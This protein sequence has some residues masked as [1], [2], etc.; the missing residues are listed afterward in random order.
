MSHYSD[1]RNI[2]SII[3][4]T[5]QGATDEALVRQCLLDNMS[6]RLPKQAAT[7][8]MIGLREAWR[9]W[10]NRHR[11][12]INQGDGTNSDL[13]I[14][15]GKAQLG[16]AME[17][18]TA[19][20]LTSPGYVVCKDELFGDLTAQEKW[21]HLFFCLQMVWRCFFSPKRANEA[22][23]IREVT[24][25]TS[26]LRLTAHKRTQKVY[27][28]IPFEKDTNLLSL[29]FKQKGIHHVLIPSAGPLATHNH[30]L[31]GDELII[32]T[33]YHKE[34]L[35]KFHHT[36]RVQ[37]VTR[38]IPER[39][40]LYI[41]R[42]LSPLA[43]TPKT[44]GFYSHGSWLRAMQSHADN[45]LRLEYAEE[46]LMQDL[47]RF[48]KKYP[49]YRLVIFAHPREKKVDILQRSR[50]YYS[51]FFD[52]NQ[53]EF[54]GAEVKTAFAFEK[55]D[56]AV[57]AFSTIQYERLFCK[58]KMLIGNYGIP[59]FPL[60]GSALQ[61]ICFN[62]YDAMESLLLKSAALSADDF[63]TSFGL[64]EYTFESPDVILP[65]A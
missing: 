44:I 16:G 50:E 23:L 35:K 25:W 49:E 38:W 13:L 27:N 45:G 4:R 29:L 62:S 14:V 10:K 41:R 2:L 21:K 1:A 24:E 39:A 60:P 53:V 54:T 34:E 58:F 61:S 7:D 37:R 6:Y 56:L 59:D 5:P 57:A 3:L 9:W 63:F 32:S 18:V 17:Y 42:Y 46:R 31:L 65:N 33:P 48:L 43:T 19:C 52:M 11:S 28:F 40:Q 36:I 55:V 51:R 47:S 22:L 30:T 15:S 12:A 64:E 26:V 20:T 8:R